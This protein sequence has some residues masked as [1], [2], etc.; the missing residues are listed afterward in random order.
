MMSGIIL[1]AMERTANGGTDTARSFSHADLFTI[2]A[3]Q[4]G[5]DDPDMWEP[6]DEP[7]IVIDTSFTDAFKAATTIAQAANLPLSVWSLV[8]NFRD[9]VTEPSKQKHRWL[10]DVQAA[11][12]VLGG[13]GTIEQIW[14]IVRFIRKARNEES[15][16]NDY[17]CCRCTL[18]KHCSTSESFEGRHDVFEHLGYGL[19]ALK[20]APINQ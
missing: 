4:P 13:A 17:S 12:V 1:E 18:P 15:G 9:H 11:L 2:H 6:M 16:V 19:W 5:P 14:Q 7:S 10:D 3:V 8:D 20:S